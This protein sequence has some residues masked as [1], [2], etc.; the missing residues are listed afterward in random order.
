MLA[1]CGR[2]PN[3]HLHALRLQLVGVERLAAQVEPA[4]ERLGCRSRDVFVL[5]RRDRDDL[6]VRVAQED[7]DQLD[8]GVAGPAEDRD[9]DLVPLRCTMP[10]RNDRRSHR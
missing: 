3:A 8:G 10:Y 9:L 1:P 4:Q 5:P 2:Q 7:L 6:G